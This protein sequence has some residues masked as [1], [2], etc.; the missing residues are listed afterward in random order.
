MKL[1]NSDPRT[2][3]RTFI[4]YYVPDMQVGAGAWATTHFN[5]NLKIRILGL[6][7][8][9]EKA[10]RQQPNEPSQEVINSWLDQMQFGGNRATIFRQDGKL[11]M[12]NKYRD[13]SS[14]KKEIVERPCA[15]GKKFQDKEGNRFGEFYL[16]DNQGNLQLWDQDGLI[17]TAKKIN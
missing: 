9:Q 10:L 1:K 2:Y 14:S 11:F 5:P 7:A 6:S 16:I 13:G 4:A 3:E 15:K 17:S 8:E 12:E